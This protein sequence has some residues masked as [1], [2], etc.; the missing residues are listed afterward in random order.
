MSNKKD[1]KKWLKIQEAKQKCCRNCS[2]L[3]QTKDGNYGCAFLQSK[4]ET[5]KSYVIVNAPDI[6]RH[7]ACFDKYN[8]LNLK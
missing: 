4:D 5:I 7:K 8:G 2:Q 6:D 3:F 1:K